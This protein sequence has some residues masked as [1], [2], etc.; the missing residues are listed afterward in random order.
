MVEKS[1]GG[2]LMKGKY[3]IVVTAGSTA[4]LTSELK[5]LHAGML[6]FSSA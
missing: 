1:E 2:A 3:Q 6:E 5:P 4:V